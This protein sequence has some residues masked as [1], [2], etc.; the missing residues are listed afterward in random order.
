MIVPSQAV[1]LEIQDKYVST[2]VLYLFI[3]CLLCLVTSMRHTRLLQVVLDN[4]ILQVTISKPQGIVTEIKFGGIDNLLEIR[5]P[6]A[7]RGY[8]GHKSS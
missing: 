4:E 8:V 5:N 6:E 1:K 3:L 2:V 7:D